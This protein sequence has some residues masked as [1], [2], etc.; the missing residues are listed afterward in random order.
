M[1]K[2]V[3]NGL[4]GLTLVLSCLLLT[5][6]SHAACKAWNLPYD[7]SEDGAN[8]ALDIC[9]ND[10][11]YFLSRDASGYQLLNRYLTPTAPT[12]KEHM[13]E[14]YF[15]PDIYFPAITKNFGPDLNISG[16]RAIWLSSTMEMHPG[17]NVDAVVAWK[18]PINGLIS[19][20][21]IFT[22]VSSA[23]G[24]GVRWHVAKNGEVLAGG[25]IPS[26]T[27]DDITYKRSKLEVLKGDMIYVITDNGGNGDI[28]CDSTRV[29]VQIKKVGN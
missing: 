17:Y 1:K 10:A 6:Q 13:G 23:C 3:K 7:F 22:D 21:T 27:L 29:A 19:L 11:W 16:D 5:A 28:G 4:M 25:V 20:T 14:E 8:P 24:D 2:I 9:G 26:L 18:S 12:L 15:A